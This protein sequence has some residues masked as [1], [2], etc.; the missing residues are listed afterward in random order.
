MDQ[1][2]R[3]TE[4]ETQDVMHKI[5][6]N[7]RDIYTHRQ[8]INQLQLDNEARRDVLDQTSDSMNE[9]G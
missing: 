9:L 5:E 7:E 2:R 4:L 8:Q 3:A 6:Q 1:K